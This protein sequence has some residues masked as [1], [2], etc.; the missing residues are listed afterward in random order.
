M[1]TVVDARVR[2]HCMVFVAIVE[3]HLTGTGSPMQRNAGRS[4]S[5]G[6]WAQN[7]NMQRAGSM[8]VRGR[9]VSPSGSGYTFEIL[10]PV[11]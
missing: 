2:Y 3:A 5:P 7:S 11:I 9:S 10:G 4:V 8:V 1:G 6:Q